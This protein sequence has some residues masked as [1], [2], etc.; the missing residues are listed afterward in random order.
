MRRL[1]LSALLLC[2]CAAQRQPPDPPTVYLRVH[3]MPVHFRSPEVFSVSE[4]NQ[5]YMVV[6]AV[7]FS[8]GPELR[9][10]ELTCGASR[11]RARESGS[12]EHEG[13]YIFRTD[14]PTARAV[15]WSLGVPATERDP[16]P[17]AMSCRIEPERRLVAC[18]ER[19][20]LRFTLQNSGPVSFWVLTGG[21]IVPGIGRDN[22]FRFEVEHAGKS[23]PSV[24]FTMFCGNDDPREIPPGECF[25]TIVDLADWFAIIEPGEY[26]VRATYG[27]ELLPSDEVPAALED[28]IRKDRELRRI[29]LHAD[30]LIEVH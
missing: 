10:I 11:L 22:H 5:E 20:P 26:K 8:P 12:D 13:V 21:M 23:L 4:D 2:A 3:G 7:D 17:V 14:A 1:A 25:D 24:E 9:G 19:I 16:W 15:A 6:L 30:A 28:G 29:D 18:A 27:A